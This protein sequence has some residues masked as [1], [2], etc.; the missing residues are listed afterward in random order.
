M[1]EAQFQRFLKDHEN[2]VEARMEEDIAALRNEYQEG[3]QRHHTMLAKINEGLNLLEEQ[4]C[5]SRRQLERVV[6]AEIKERQ[7]RDV[8]SRQ[9]L[10]GV[11]VSFG[12]EISNRGVA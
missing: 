9:Q 5:E 4:F 12:G 3:H 8:W 6:A 1:V 11:Q 2:D 7:Q 10:E